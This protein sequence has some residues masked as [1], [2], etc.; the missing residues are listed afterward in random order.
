MADDQVTS[1]V[2]ELRRELNHH[3]HRYYVLDDPTA[4]PDAEYDRL[5]VELR[6]LEE[7]HPELVTADS[8]TQRVGAAPAEGF[9][10]V[11]HR[12]PMLSLAQ[13]L[14]P[15]GVGGLVPAGEETAGLRRL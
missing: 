2:A 4:M 10:Q 3:N 15:G 9:N 13:R 11:Q 1:R 5:M 12:L 14:Q 8:P 7:L 6:G